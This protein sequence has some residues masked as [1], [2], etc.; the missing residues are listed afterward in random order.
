M[1]TRNLGRSL[2]VGLLLAGAASAQVLRNPSF[3]SPGDSTDLAAGWN[4]WGDWLNREEGWTPTHSGKCLLGYHHWQ[5]PDAKD[6]GVYQDVVGAKKDGA[7]EFGIHA[8]LDKAKD[9]TRDPLTIELRLEATVDDHQ[10]TLASKL[11]RVAD[12]KPGHWEKLTV[13]G[14]T[15][16]DTLRVLV[17]VTPSADDASRGGA[18]RFDDAFLNQAN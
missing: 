17:I 9:S 11:Y 6:S 3:E 10:Q 15:T 16:N 12:L 18:I 2:G 1:R 5:I 8:N 13:T 7:Y 4:R 14:K